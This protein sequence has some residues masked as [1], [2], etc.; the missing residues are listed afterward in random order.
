MATSPHIN[1][2]DCGELNYELEDDSEDICVSKEYD[3]DEE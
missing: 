3:S 2:P 1:F